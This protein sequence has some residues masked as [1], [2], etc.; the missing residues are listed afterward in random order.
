MF[1]VRAEVGV[2]S[3]Q[4]R[5]ERHRS[6]EHEAFGAAG[7]YLLAGMADDQKRIDDVVTAADIDLLQAAVVQLAQLAVAAL[8]RDRHEAPREVVQS[9]VSAAVE[10]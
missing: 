1:G 5:A 6:R 8:A 3:R 4:R 2:F 9:L 7:E 10:R